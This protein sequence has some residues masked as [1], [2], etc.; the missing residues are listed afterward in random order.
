M[1]TIFDSLNTAGN[2]SIGQY[3]RSSK[4]LV[5]HYRD[6]IAQAG[7]DPGHRFIETASRGIGAIAPGPARAERGLTDGA[8]SLVPWTERQHGQIDSQCRLCTNG[9]LS[10]SLWQGLSA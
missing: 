2:I 6:S 3:N 10:H 4:R 1:R 5:Q 7:S 9:E 8:G